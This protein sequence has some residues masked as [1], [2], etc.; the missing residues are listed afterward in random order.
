MKTRAV[1]ILF[2]MSVYISA[3]TNFPTSL[4]PRSSSSAPASQAA[5]ATASTMD[6]LVANTEIPTATNTPFITSVVASPDPNGTATPTQTPVSFVNPDDE[7]PEGEIQIYVPGDLSR[8]ISPFRFVANL[9]PSPNNTVLIELLGEDGRVLTRK[10][11]LAFPARSEKRVNAITDI[12]FE[13]DELAEA[14]RL[15]VSVEDEYG[16]VHAVASVNLILMSTGMTQMNP[17]VD[18]FENIIIQQ[19]SANVMVQ[20]TSLTVTGLA[21]TQSDN[22]LQIELIDRDGKV[23]AF[24]FASVFKSEGEDYGF[25][26]LEI[27]YIVSEPIWVMIA[28]QENALRVPGPIHRSS[29]EMVISP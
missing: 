14:G 29:I 9:Q 10:I 13:I 25:F 27:R 19:P 20:G 12:D 11:I 24:G 21:R 6:T 2:C 28:V 4:D 8:V 22:L 16:R 15:I 18:I 3:C 5:V 7:V 26:A 23:I 1:V 17:Y